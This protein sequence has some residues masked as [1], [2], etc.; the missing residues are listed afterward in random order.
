[1][2]CLLL[3]LCLIGLPLVAQA[4]DVMTAQVQTDQGVQR[5]TLELAQTS[6]ERQRGLMYRQS[7]PKDHGMW[8]DLGYEQRASMW[9]KNTYIP[10]DILFLNKHQVIMYIE[11]HTKP[12]S[13]ERI[14]SPTPVRYVLEINAGSAKAFGLKPG[15]RFQLLQNREI[16]E[17]IRAE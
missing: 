8:F 14:T 5:L 7:M 6:E 4:A 2:K 3:Y 10:L 9:M 12:H 1:M 17:K 16:G 11:E 13:L 15:Q